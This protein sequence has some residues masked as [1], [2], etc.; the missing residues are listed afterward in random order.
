M[1]ASFARISRG[2]LA[3]RKRGFTLVEMLAATAVFIM[4]VTLLLSAV[5]Q[6]SNAWQTAE[7]QKMRR[8]RARSALDLISRDLQS[9]ITPL[10]GKNLTHPTSFLMNPESGHP[11]DTIFWRTLSPANR[12]ASDITVVGYFVNDAKELCRYQ[13]NAS[14]TFTLEEAAQAAAN[15]KPGKENDYQG[16]LTE[17]VL[18][19]F[20][21]L[22]NEKGALV[23]TGGKEIVKSGAQQ[24]YQAS[25]PASAEVSLVIADPR[26][27]KKKPDLAVSWPLE[28]TAE[29]GVQVFTTRVD[30]PAVR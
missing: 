30:L 25:L 21:T 9:A 4:M 11:A 12:K 2:V 22:F 15:L 5:S 8:E 23:E 3:A 18:G 20:V 7:A 26:T 28:E 24:N 1:Q 10:P 19:L 27:L 6:T 13:T 16:L 14:M 29:K 17:G